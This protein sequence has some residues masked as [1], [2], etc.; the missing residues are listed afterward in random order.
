MDPRWCI[1][2]L[3][4]H[5]Y[6]K[7]AAITEP[8]QHYL[9]LLSVWLGLS[10]TASKKLLCVHYYLPCLWNQC[11]VKATARQQAKV[12][13]S[14]SSWWEH[15]EQLDICPDFVIPMAKLQP[16]LNV[17][18]LYVGKCSDRCD[19]S[20]NNGLHSTLCVCVPFPNHSSFLEICLHKCPTADSHNCADLWLASFDLTN[21]VWTW[22]QVSVRKCALA[23]RWVSEEVHVLEQRARL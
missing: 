5:P 7:L 4:V 13:I 22:A 9:I 10:G 2:W 1:C 14:P 17:F 11:K 12:I 18:S 20:N 3:P 15:T 6:N 19:R 16:G 21:A 8:K 23:S